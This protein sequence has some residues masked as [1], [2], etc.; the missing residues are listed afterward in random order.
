MGGGSCQ[1][2]ITTDLNPTKASVWKVIKSIEGGCP[3]RDTSGNLPDVSDLEWPLSDIY[4][5]TIPD[6]A[7][8]RYTL[9]W[10]WFNKVAQRQM[11]M[12]CAPIEIIGGAGSVQMESLPDMFVANMMEYKDCMNME[13]TDLLF[14]EPGADLDQ[15]NG[16]TTAFAAAFGTECTGTPIP[17]IPVDDIPSVTTHDIAP[18]VVP[19]PPKIG[20]ISDVVSDPVD[21]PIIDEVKTEVEVPEDIP[22]YPGVTKV[23]KYSPRTPCPEASEKPCNCIDGLT[24]QLCE[25]GAW[26]DIMPI[27]D[28]WVCFAGQAVQLAQR[29]AEI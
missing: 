1:I 5:F 13:G 15:L 12:D 2:S 20:P 24:Y 4:N 27:T 16:A 18:T 25:D 19:L 29:P 10:T 14:P 11:H 9:A 7:S 21:Q 28:G 6:V 23:Y 22:M 3:A 26:T 17:N 8:G